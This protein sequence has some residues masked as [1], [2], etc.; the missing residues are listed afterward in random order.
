MPIKR[1][2][3]W[4]G[5]GL[6]LAALLLVP[7]LLA[8][9]RMFAV[10][11]PSMGTAAPVG[12]L[13]ITTTQP[14]Y[15]VGDIISFR[16]GERTHTHR[17][18][19][20]RPDG[21]YVTKGD[22]NGVADPLPVRPAD[23]I[24][25][26][27]AILPGLG[28]LFTGLPWLLGGALAV[29]FLTAR[30]KLAARHRA[31]LR[32]LG[33][34]V[35]FC[36]V[37]LWLRPWL[38]VNMLGFTPADNGGVLMHVVNTGLFPLDALGSRLVSGQDAVVH[39]T[40]AGEGGLYILTPTP[41]LEWWQL[42]ILIIVC[43]TPMA[44][45]LLMRVEDELG[46]EI[47]PTH[48]PRHPALATAAIVV[49]TTLAVTAFATSSAWAA[50]TA[51]IQNTTSTAGT[52]SFFTCRN[53]ISSLGAGS[54]F[55]AWGLT[56]TSTSEADVSGNGRTG[57]YLRNPTT[58]TSIACS[59][60]TPARSVT[61]NGNQCLYMN[62]GTNT[63]QTNPSTFSIEAWFRTGTKSNGKIIGYGNVRNNA[64]DTTY[65]RH[66]YLDKDGRIVFGVYPGA[67]KLTS[68]PAGT[69]YADNAWHHAVGTLSAAG[70]KLYV[71]GELVDT[72]TT[73]TTAENTTGYWK[74]GC[75]N[76]TN[77]QNAATGDTGS[78]NLDY[79]GPNYFTGQIQYAAVYTVALTAQQVKDHYQAGT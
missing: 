67:V 58:S 30:P 31:A 28:W 59:E 23:V 3:L 68:T 4:G 20:V 54:T 62:S 73:V 78:T 63:S 18:V 26:A 11:T 76:L 46:E 57:R 47:H 43:L 2:A 71:D 50:P 70:Q 61:F 37:A 12:T 1:L 5:A 19:Q 48:T 14:A 65:D 29:Y 25:K 75:G 53:A 56:S 52:R 60:D 64:S 39:L 24:G 51:K 42:A 13:V 16:S 32:I 6:A 21:Q 15:E 34:T 7:A 72:N 35:V 45:S 69:S 55:V 36:A 41:A 38:N 49:A 79:S 74:V 33:T 10:Q 9:V 8:G 40:Q 66:L 77:W 22:L 44:A 17:I 27:A